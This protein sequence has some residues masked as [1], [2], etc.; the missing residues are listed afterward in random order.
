MKKILSIVLV[1]VLLLG[2]IPAFAES[3]HPLAGKNVTL[4]ILG[5]GGWVP[6]SLAQE[7]GQELFADYAKENFGYNVTVTF[8]ESPFDMLFQ[9]AATSLASGANEYNLIISDSQWLGALSE[10]GWIVKL[11]D[12]I[13]ENPNLD[14]DWY[15]KSASDAYM[16]YP[17]GTDNIWGLPQEADVLMMYVRAD[18]LT[19]ET[20]RKNFVEKY[21][22]ELPKDS[23]V[24]EWEDIDYV[25]YE[26]IC[27]FFTRPDEN[28]YGTT[29]QFSKIYD[30][31][32]GSLY[33]Y[34]WSAGEEV[35]D[36]VTGKVS[37][38]L[39]TDKN[40]EMLA[41][42]KSMIKYCPPGALDVDIGGITDNFNSGKVVTAWQWAAMGASMTP[43][44]TDTWGV[45]L[46]G[47]RMEDGTVNRTSS[48]G[49]QPWVINA[50]NTEEQMTVVL[51]FLNWWYTDEIQLEFARRGG[52][53][54][55]KN[56]L[57]SEGF[58]ELQP[59]FSAY[60]YMMLDG[61]SKDF[62]HHP[63]YAELL[64]IQQEAWSAYMAGEDG[65]VEKAKA[66][67]DDIA[68]KQDVVMGN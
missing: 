15:S 51:D 24:E 25:K 47:Y 17:D 26:Q 48:L 67:L 9:K 57:N 63:A 55:G 43:S 31:L 32:T 20:E 21:G 6:S 42:S 66:V 5:I 13:A 41:L 30:F 54:L 49:G 10:A 68:A 39:N 12:I 40:A 52:S 29:I 38:V 14:V 23:S 18:K 62:W 33:P 61:N 27:E 2:S 35:W 36:P 64:A 45:I 50:F 59:W 28:L 37:G 22:W 1:C 53:P 34:F 56:V 16:I 7:M 46:P 11:N 60:K 8:A 4:S 44:G 58:E 3:G 19:D 65:S